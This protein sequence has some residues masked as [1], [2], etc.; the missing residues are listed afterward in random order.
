MCTWQEHFYFEIWSAN[1]LQLNISV[2]FSLTHLSM[3]AVV[4]DNAQRILPLRCKHIPRHGINGQRTRKSTTTNASWC[5][6]QKNPNCVFCQTPESYNS[7]GSNIL[8]CRL[9]SHTSS[10]QNVL[11]D[12]GTKS[13]IITCKERQKT[14]SMGEITSTKDAVARAKALY[15]CVLT[16]NSHLRKLKWIAVLLPKPELLMPIYFFLLYFSC[17]FWIQGFVLEMIKE[18]GYEIMNREHSTRAENI[19]KLILCNIDVNKA[20]IITDLFENKGKCKIAKSQT[21]Q[22]VKFIGKYQHRYRRCRTKVC[23]FRLISIIIFNVRYW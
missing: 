18:R 10:R 17:D 14:D 2:F 4:V 12:P 21:S 11:S 15:N 23:L 16:V 7:T 19:I 13:N 3:F 20:E 5:K 6:L 1:S 22:D 8:L 9:L